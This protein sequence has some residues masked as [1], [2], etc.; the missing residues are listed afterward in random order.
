MTFYQVSDT[1]INSNCRKPF[2]SFSQREDRANLMSVSPVAGSLPR[3]RRRNKSRKLRRQRRRG[4]RSRVSKVRVV[5]G[6]VTLRLGGRPGV[7]RVPASQ[8][9]RHVPLKN[10]R[11]AAQRVIRRGAVNQ[12]RRRRRRRQ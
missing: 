12:N 5:N 4:A 11:L 6:Q 2:V 7:Q 3:R 8:I 10:I 1:N 9:V